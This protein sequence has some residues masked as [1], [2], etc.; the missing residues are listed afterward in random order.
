MQKSLFIIFLFIGL[1]LNAQ[2]Q[3]DYSKVKI[4]LLDK[5][6]QELQALEL[7][8]DHGEHKRNTWFV[9]DLS[10]IEIALAKQAGFTVDIL[11]E[12]VQAFYRERNQTPNTKNAKAINCN[13]SFEF[14]DPTN[15][16][17]GSMG[18]FLTYDE[19]LEELDS[20]VAKY[21]NLISARAPI[22]TFVSHEGRPIEWLRISNTPNTDDFSKPEILY[23]ALHHAREPASM[24]QLIY[25]MWY[26]LENYDTNPELA[27]IVDNVE[28]YF[29]PCIN[30]DG[31]VYN[32]Q[33]DPNGGGLH[34]KNRRNVGTNNQGVDLNRNYAY[35]FGGPGTSTNP[36]SDLY[37]GT[38]AF[39]EPE[40]QAMEWLSENHTFKIAL[41]YHS[42][43]DALLFPWGYEDAFQ[44]PDH[45]AF[46]FLTDE[47]VRENNYNNYQSSLLYEAAGDSD[48]W[49]YG[50]TTNKPK[51]FALTPEVGSEDDGF[52]PAANDILGICRENVYQN[53]TAALSLLDNYSLTDNSPSIIEHG[54]FSLPLEL[55][56]LGFLDTDY[57]LTLSSVDASISGV[58]NSQVAITPNFGDA[59]TVTFTGLIDPSFVPLE[60]IKFVVTVN[61]N[62]Y[63]FYDTITKQIGLGV[64]LFEDVDASMNSWTNTGSWGKDNDAYSAPTSTSDSPN[65]NYGN[66]QTND[67]ISNP[68]NL[69]FMRFAELS[70]FAKWDIEQGYDYAQI[71]VSSDGGS[72][73]TP[74]CGDYTIL[75]ND[76]QDENEPVYDG[77]NPSW[78]KESIDLSSFLGEIIQ[79]RFRLKSDNFTTGEGFKFDDLKIVAVVDSTQTGV[80]DLNEIAFQLFP[81]PTKNSITIL[82]NLEN[83]SRYVIRNVLGQEILQE[84]LTASRITLNV[85]HLSPG[86]YFMY[87]ENED[88][89]VG[90]RQ[91][92][93]LDRN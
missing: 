30:P 72:S 31:Y 75:G 80:R 86:T 24:Q 1:S 44:C 90:V 19:M 83:G 65:G 3:A 49:M 9:T 55:Q 7:A 43:A 87:I 41:N 34:R 8:T 18:G 62:N 68:I 45:D 39:S 52:W 91:F 59:A 16:N 51:I 79:L 77:T 56:R 35:E 2:N 27:Y 17:S 6:I 70:F 82:S 81:N 88:G 61:S 13:A 64:T 71:S 32:E 25:Y 37:H 74:L 92:V 36:N 60:S 23:S 15:Y 28:M 26:V 20:M 29:V 38:G 46:V 50:D 73:W 93:V 57:T 85:S 53:Y 48:D 33:T 14:D 69:G 84:E 22:S 63:T 76:N 89:Q 47:M 67:L 4:W 78:V 58:N 11:I 21:P 12:D 54:N 5:S 40:T 66:G 10:N 42:Y